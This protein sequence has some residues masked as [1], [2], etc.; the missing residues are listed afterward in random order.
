[1]MQHIMLILGQ[2]GRLAKSEAP[3][4]STLNRNPKLDEDPILVVAPSS[5]RGATWPH[6]WDQPHT[7]ELD[8]F[9]ALGF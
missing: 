1:M 7:S 9:M 8:R 2:S 3:K 4:P 5:L 6:F